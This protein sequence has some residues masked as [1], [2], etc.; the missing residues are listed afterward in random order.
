MNIK[1]LSFNELANCRILARKE[2]LESGRLV[3]FQEVAEREI[4]KYYQGKP[5]I[6][7][8]RSSLSDDNIGKFIYIEFDN[9]DCKRIQ[10]VESSNSINPDMSIISTSSPVGKLIKNCKK[11]QVF[12]FGKTMFRI[13]DITN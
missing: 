11:N 2:S 12:H 10:L 13:L 7:M 4:S 1:N 3:T 8:H 6:V 9:G 5:S